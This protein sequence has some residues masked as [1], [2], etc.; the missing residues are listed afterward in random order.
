MLNS[1]LDDMTP[2]QREEVHQR[3]LSNIKLM[4]SR[5]ELAEI[6]KMKTQAEEHEKWLSEKPQRDAAEKAWQEGKPARDAAEKASRDKAAM[7]AATYHKAQR[8]AIMQG[9]RNDYPHLSVERRTAINEKVFNN[10]RGNYIFAGLGGRGKTTL[11]KALAALAEADGLHTVVT[12]TLAWEA[13]TRSIIAA[14]FEDKREHLSEYLRRVQHVFVGIDEI[15]KCAKTEFMLNHLHAVLDAAVENGH[16]VVITTN[17]P[18]LEEFRKV[19]GDSIEWRVMLP[20]D[21][22]GRGGLGCTW[23]TFADS[24]V[25]NERA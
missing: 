3:V 12:D 11:L 10:T 9:I 7:A 13:K 23:I 14:P 5:A 21:K 4:Q 25:T 8:S 18:T 16:Q 1:V 22:A 20:R 24:E 2:E 19:F 17:I 15:D 6:E